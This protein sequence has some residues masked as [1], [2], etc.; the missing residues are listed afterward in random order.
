MNPS[1][2]D[3]GS[4]SL[5]FAIFA[6][7]VSITLLLC[8]M[9]SAERDDLDEFYTG[10]RTLAP[11]RNGLAIAGDYISAATVLSTIGIIALTGFD[12][13]LLALSTALSLLLLM[14]LLAEPLRNAGRFTM[15]DALTHRA[16]SR[17][18]R[19]AATAVTLAAL[20]PLMVFQLSGAGHL[21]TLVLGFEGSSVRTATIVALGGLMIGYAAIGGMKGTALIH[22][23]KLVVLFGA[24]L[25]LALL[26]MDKVGWNPSRLVTLA[27][28]GSG[29]GAAYAR[30]GLLIQPTSIGK[31]D[32]VASSLTVVFGAACL[33]HV[34]MRM[35][36]ARN[37]PDIRRAMSYA[38]MI[39]AVFV[40]LIAV[41]GAG[42][43]ALL[44]REVLAAGDPEGSTAILQLAR[45]I[46]ADSAAL[47]T[48]VF[49]TVSTAVFLTLLSSVAGMI[50]ACGNSL[51]HDLYAHV[52][53]RTGEPSPRREQ[54]VARLAAFAVGA[55][56]IAL[57]VL[58]QDKALRALII[59]SFSIAASAIAPALVYSLF[60]RRFTRLG[61]LGTLIGGT[62]A[63]IVVTAY[64]TTISGTPQSLFPD[65]DFDI[66]PL[67]TSGMI[68]IPVGFLLG[69]AGTFLSSRR[70]QDQ[71]RTE[72]RAA[73][74]RLLAG[75]R[76]R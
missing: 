12:G 33:P 15:G 40:L 27:D 31:V 53:T 19:L 24:S 74:P 26:V 14:V 46:V 47:S 70:K 42:A 44:G 17:L 39:M 66:F 36:T 65:K 2:V 28:I 37:A 52:M 67:T 76:R 23:I 62:A 73:E 13:L 71:G 25:M 56:A 16:P 51:A 59:L 5:S 55:P 48:F 11:L 72:Y 3:A 58:V 8:I 6:A 21:V 1:S 22:I 10:F 50:L 45:A 61:L 32:L 69:W 54:I 49:T 60:W 41:I 30:S 9:T 38:V 35:F 64:S 4:Q 7:L 43:T 29:Q 68:S 20:L 18:V 75:A 63:A 57:A 34:T